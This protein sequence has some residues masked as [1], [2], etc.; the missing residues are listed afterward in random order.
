MADETS[1]TNL[2]AVFLIGMMGSLAANLV[3]ELY[4]KSKETDKKYG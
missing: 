2:M 1:E 4:K 3:I